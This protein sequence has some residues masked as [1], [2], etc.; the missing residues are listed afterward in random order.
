MINVQV[1]TKR[2]VPLLQWI[3]VW[4]DPEVGI[5]P[6]VVIRLLPGI[7]DCLRVPLLKLFH[8]FYLIVAVNVGLVMLRG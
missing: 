4:F 1:D 7:R 6:D 8:Q 2:P 3:G 5:T